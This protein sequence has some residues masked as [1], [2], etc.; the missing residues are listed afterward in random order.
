MNTSNDIA[1]VRHYAVTFAQCFDATIFGRVVVMT[2]AEE[3]QLRNALLA[4]QNIG[5]VLSP[6]IDPMAPVYGLRDIIEHL[7]TAVGSQI[8]DLALA[9]VSP[10]EKPAPAVLMPVWAFEPEGESDDVLLSSGTLWGTDMLFEALRVVD[11]DNPEP[12]PAVRDRFLR[13]ALAAGGRINLTTT[14]L[15]GRDARYVLFAAAA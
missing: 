15:P 7:R 13:W 6:S 1:D 2:A 11:D 4:L 3:L 14:R 8:V 10:G 12:V 9:T 5:C